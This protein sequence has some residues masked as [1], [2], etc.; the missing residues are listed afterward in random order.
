MGKWMYISAVSKLRKYMVVSVQL[1]V[2]AALVPGKE[3]M[4]SL[5]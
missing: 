2:A 1:H 5:E 3:P 4:V